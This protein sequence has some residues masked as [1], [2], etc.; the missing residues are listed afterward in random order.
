MNEERQAVEV[1]MSLFSHVPDQEVARFDGQTLRQRVE[2]WVAH[3][4]EQVEADV[5]EAQ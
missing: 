4:I 2:A 5:E 3:A 1:L